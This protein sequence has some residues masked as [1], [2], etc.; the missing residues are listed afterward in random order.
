MSPFR[1]AQAKRNHQAYELLEAQSYTDWAITTLFYCAMQLV[2]HWLVQETGKPPK[3]HRGREE[4]LIKAKVPQDVLDAYAHLY[5]LSHIARYEDWQ[6]RFGASD[7]LIA[8]TQKY[9]QVCTYFRA[10]Q[11]IRPS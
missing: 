3:S 5:H 7:V 4:A 10:P 9:A 6:R 11:D 2:N 1:I 8:Y